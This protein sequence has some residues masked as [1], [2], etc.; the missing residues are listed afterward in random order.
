MIYQKQELISEGKTKRVWA[1]NNPRHAIAEFYDDAMMYHAKK[2]V[3][4]KNK[5][6]YCNQIN[7][8]L[9]SILEDNSIATHFVQKHSDC[10]MV[11]RRAEMIPVEVV[12]RN[13]VAGSMADRLGLEPF[14]KLKSP[15]LEFCDKNDELNDPV[16]NEYHACAMDL[17]T[18]EEMS[19]MV[20]TA[21]RV[22]KLL[23]EVMKKIGI[24][25]ADFKLEFGR[26]N[27]RLVVADE[28]T[29][30]C[31]RFWDEETLLRFDHKD[32][33]PEYEYA[34][35]LRRLQENYHY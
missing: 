6:K 14:S 2:K 11:V 24:V 12:V 23:C 13:Y 22:N 8:I 3:Y 5:S 1:T 4:F 15:V 7:C 26:V 10:E 34:E 30:N 17:C 21:S 33:N 9:M 28:I 35:I 27:G 29:P 31:A 25:V 16:I 19:L 20:Y 32:V 18:P